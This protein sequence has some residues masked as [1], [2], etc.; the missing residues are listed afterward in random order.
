MRAGIFVL[1][2]LASLAS[3]GYAQTFSETI[4]KEMSF[5]KK[6][7]DNAVI[8]ANINGSIRVVGYD[9]DKVVLE[10]EKKINAKT[11]ERLEQGKQQIQLGVIDN[12]DTLIF[13]V[14]GGC[15]TFSKNTKHG[16][17][18]YNWNNCNNNNSCHEG[19]DYNMNF[20]L[21]IPSAVHLTVSTIND[22][23]ISVENVKGKVNANNING[24]IKLSNLTQAAVASTIN[25]NVDVEYSQNPQ[26][27]CRFYTLNGD[28]NANFQKG[29]G[30]KLSFESFNG[31][32]Y[33]N[34]DQLVPLPLIMEKGNI[35]KGIKYKVKGNNYQVGKGGALLDFE[36]FNGNVYLKEKTN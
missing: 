14:S 3:I 26:T 16:T 17:W 22:G 4:K 21:K 30:A 28:I 5:E 23:D 7:S 34:V 15:N 11:S 27:D 31:N 36:T 25:G 2:I 1:V 18:G 8:V 24:H 10:V 32:F 6:S 35:D 12:V 29:L 19:Y 13:Y 9:G 33:T 20:T